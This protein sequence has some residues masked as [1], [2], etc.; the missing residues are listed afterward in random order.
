M[1]FFIHVQRNH[2]PRVGGSSPSSATKLP[3][4]NNFKR[5]ITP[6]LWCN[7]LMIVRHQTL[8]A[9]LKAEGEG[10]SQRPSAA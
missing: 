3:Q 10:W 1:V 4:K 6:S 2:N 5:L 9:Q 7:Y 8:N